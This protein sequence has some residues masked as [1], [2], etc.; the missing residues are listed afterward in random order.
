MADLTLAIDKAAGRANDIITNYNRK[1]VSS[2][3]PGIEPSS[4]H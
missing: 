4:P 3:T 2:P 1:K